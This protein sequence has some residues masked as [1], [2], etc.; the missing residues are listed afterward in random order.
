MYKKLILI[1]FGD[2]MLKGKN[3]KT[4]IN[5]IKRLIKDKLSDLNVTIINTYNRV[6]LDINDVSPDLVVKRL[7]LVSGLHSFSFVYKTSLELEDIKNTAIKLIEDELTDFNHFKIET[8]RAYKQFPHTSLEFSKIIAPAILK[9]FEG[10]ITVD[11][12]NPTE[13]LT[14]EIREDG[15][16]L[17]LKTIKGLGGY[18]VGTGGK[19]LVMLSGGIDSPVAAF[20]ALKQGVEIE[21]LHFE[22]SP[23]TPLESVDKV[24]KIASKIARYMPK[25]QIKMHM[26]HFADLHHMLLENVPDPYIITIMRRRMYDIAEK[27]AKKNNILVLINGESIG[28][29]ASQTLE[30]L[31]VV[32]AVTRMPIIRPLATYDKNDIIKIAHQIDT[33]ETSIIPFEDCCTVYV[34]KKPVTKPKLQICEQIESNFDFK[35]VQEETINGI[36]TFTVHAN[37]E[38]KLAN[39]GFDFKDAYEVWRNDHEPSK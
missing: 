30:S 1:R 4:F 37:K 2:L 15:T 12:K 11:V 16:Y 10:K 36:T 26:C 38:M 39:Y 5:A 24:I 27:H 23:L 20:L 31:S 14:I 35:V 3:Q 18:P 32:E 19:G 7:M 6:Y 13:T 25:G 22:S 17:F 21:L 9:R 28:Q 29:V 34:P 33:Y 8:K